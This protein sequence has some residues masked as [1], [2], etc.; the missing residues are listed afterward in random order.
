M[1]T[2]SL[3]LPKSLHDLAREVAKEEDI[4]INQLITLALAEKLS[5]LKTEEY[6]EQR[7]KGSSRAKF[8]RALAKVSKQEPAAED[9]LQRRAK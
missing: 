8:E 2:L 6:F 3:R 1:S 7:A 5:A 9:R 4:S